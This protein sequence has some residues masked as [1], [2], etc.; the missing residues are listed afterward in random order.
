MCSGHHSRLVETLSESAP[1][2]ASSSRMVL[3]GS[4][5]D[6]LLELSPLLDKDVQLF[7]SGQR[8]WLVGGVFALPSRPK[9]ASC[10]TKS[11]GMLFSNRL[12]NLLGV[13]TFYD[14][15]GLGGRWANAYVLSALLVGFIVMVG[16]LEEVGHED[17]R[18]DRHSS[19]PHLREGVRCLVVTS[20]TWFNSRP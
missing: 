20:G 19:R 4:A 13:P 14:N 5:M 10:W 7:P 1:H 11:F 3:T 18:W 6:V 8:T 16:G 17:P 9:G 12:R 2:K 15:N